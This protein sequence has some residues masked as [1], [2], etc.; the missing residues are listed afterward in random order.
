MPKQRRASL[1]APVRVDALLPQY[2]PLLTREEAAA[3]ISEHFFPI[4]PRTLERWPVSIKRLNGKACLITRE[5]FE[6]AQRRV[7]TAPQ[8]AA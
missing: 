3:A 7:D 1:A 2:R 6:E 8:V 4:K 5:V